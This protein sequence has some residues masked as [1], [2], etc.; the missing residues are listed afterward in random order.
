MLHR[1]IQYDSLERRTLPAK[2]VTRI[3]GTLDPDMDAACNCQVLVQNDVL[4]NRA[5]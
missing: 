3:A 2:Q 1:Q 5:K 4:T